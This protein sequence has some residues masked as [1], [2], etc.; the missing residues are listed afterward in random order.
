M[1]AVIGFMEWILILFVFSAYVF[2]P[3]AVIAFVVWLTLRK[4][5]PTA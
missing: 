1:F 3:L 5:K 4:R 2:V